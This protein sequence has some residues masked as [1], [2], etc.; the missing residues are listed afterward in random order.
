M[1]INLKDLAGNIVAT[2][3][4]D[5]SG[6]Y[7][8]LNVA[9]GQYTIMEVQPTGY[10]SVSD[11]DATPDPDGNDG[12]T[13][14]D[15]IPVTVTAGENDNDNNLVEEQTGSIRG[16][17]TKDTNNDNV[18]DSPLAN[19]TINLKDPAGNI[20]ATDV[21]DAQETVLECSSGQYT[22]WKYSLR[23]TCK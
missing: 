16:T 7:E 6:N 12:T 19:V 14:N 3:V 1:T 23:D 11:V 22:I 15:M 4:T 9:P 13:P 17:V 10:N 20:V 8:F 18:G 5:A 2:D 21:T